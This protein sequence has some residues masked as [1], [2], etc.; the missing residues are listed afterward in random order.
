MT[1]TPDVHD[2]IPRFIG[3]PQLQHVPLDE[4]TASFDSALRAGSG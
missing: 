4:V 2:A 1:Q 3:P